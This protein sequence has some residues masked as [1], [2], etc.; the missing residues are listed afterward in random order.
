MTVEWFGDK[1]LEATNKAMVRVC[2]SSAENVMADAKKI[3]KQKAKTTSELGLLSQFY[4][5]KSKYETGGYIV[6]CQGPKNWHPPYHASFLEMGTFKDEAKPFMRPAYKKNRRK[7]NKMFQ[8][9]AD[10]L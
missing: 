7:A 5:E 10:K 2:K 4:V 9:E 6:W 1:I 8:D 3:L